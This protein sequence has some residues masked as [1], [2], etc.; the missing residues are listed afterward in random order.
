MKPVEDNAKLILKAMIEGHQKKAN[1]DA[2]KRLTNLRSKEI[3]AAVPFLESQDLI[4]TAPVIK[5]IR[6]DFFH[7][8]ISQKGYNFYSETYHRQETPDS[9]PF[10]SLLYG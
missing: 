3:N 5:N 9:D 7:I 2:I 1:G 8:T 10:S 6:Y 4:I